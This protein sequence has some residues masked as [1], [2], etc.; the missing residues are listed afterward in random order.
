VPEQRAER[1][2]SQQASPDAQVEA[3]IDAFL[4]GRNSDP[5]ALLGPQPV[6]TPSGR[7]WVIRFFH[8]HAASASVRV[9][10]VAGDIEARK[11]REEGLFEATLP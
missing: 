8:P 1:S 10:G 7:R 11:R 6:G 3:H 4:G 2:V 5:F 9:S